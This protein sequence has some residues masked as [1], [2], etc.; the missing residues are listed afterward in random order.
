MP[1]TTK[2]RSRSAAKKGRKRDRK[3]NAKT[4]DRYELYQ[5]AVNS[6]DTDVDFLI[7]AFQELRGRE[8]RHLREDFC[9][10][11]A[12]AAE[13]ISRG[14]QK[15]AEGFDLDPEPVEWGK[16]HNFA[17][18]GDAVERMT[19]HLE[20]VRGRADRRPDI[21]TAANFSYWCFQTREDLL[22]YFRGVHADLTDD[23]IFV[24][25]LYGGP[26]ALTEMEE[27]RDIGG[28]IDYVWDQREWWP[29][30]G[31]YACSIHFRFK[32]GSELTDA[33]SYVWRFWNLT[34]LKDVLRDAGFGSVNPYFEGTDEDDE[35]S[36]D[37]VFEL[38][39]R[40]EN[41]EAWIGY[42]VAEK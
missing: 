15:T 29:G 26:E 8:P 34:E 1:G 12:L 16:R 23:G 36:G 6:P 11:A 42:L 33:F 25:D 3:L 31:E 38:D 19:F 4:A 21:T 7:N 28:G 9:G 41:C 40:G 18:L 20:D 27:I 5:R 24:I 37:G 14:E 35:E 32:D 30:T 17:K 2:K 10:T 13:W 39:Q 22:D